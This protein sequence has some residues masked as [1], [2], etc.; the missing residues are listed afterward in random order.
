VSGLC[1]TRSADRR[2]RLLDFEDQSAE[3][4]E[5][6]AA[7]PEHFERASIAEVS[8]GMSRV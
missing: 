1:K 4:E 2:H 6:D 7:D 5:R 3:P 8:I